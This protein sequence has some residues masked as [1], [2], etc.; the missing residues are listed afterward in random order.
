MSEAWVVNASPLILLARIDRLDIIE[1]LV[2]AIL[3]PHAVIDEVRAG[4]EKDPRRQARLTGRHGTT[5]QTSGSR[6]RSSTGILGWARP[7]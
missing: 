2:P 6:P 1:R 3:V 4:Q 7:R 5:S